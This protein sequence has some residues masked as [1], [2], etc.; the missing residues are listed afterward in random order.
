LRNNHSLASVNG[1]GAIW[2]FGKISK[3]SKKELKENILH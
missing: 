3:L 1:L 2:S